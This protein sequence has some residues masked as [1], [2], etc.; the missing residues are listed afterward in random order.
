LAWPEEHV[1]RVRAGAVAGGVMLLVSLWTL[2]AGAGEPQVHLV[3]AWF[4]AMA[5]ALVALISLGLAV[6]VNRGLPDTPSARRQGQQLTR[7]EAA[8]VAA[9]VLAGL[10]ALPLT[11]YSA[12]YL[13]ANTQPAVS[14]TAELGGGTIRAGRAAVAVTV[15][16]GNSGTT[17]ARLIGSMYT[18]AGVTLND[19]AD[20]EPTPTQR[21]RI[22]QPS[23][24]IRWIQRLATTTGLVRGTAPQRGSG[25]RD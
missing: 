15:K 17:S 7:A 5:V 24:S 9:T 12:H 19:A 18:L 10:V 22:H 21:G 20:A 2:G 11:W 3:L 8:G 16:V 25:R 13:P 14:V 6:F 4:V 1:F 23:T